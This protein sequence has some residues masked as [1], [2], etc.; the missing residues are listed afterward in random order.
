MDEMISMRTKLRSKAT[1]LGNDLRAYRQGD[2]KLMDQDQLALKIHHIEKIGSELRDVQIQLDKEGRSDDSDHI[3][4]VEDEVFLSSRLLARLEKAAEARGREKDDKRGPTLNMD[5]KSSL[6]IKFPTFYG[7]VMKW[8]EF[9][10]LYTASVHDNP[11]VVDVQKFV[12]LKSHLAGVALRAIQSIPVSADGY[13]EAIAVLKE[14]FELKD[15][16]RERLMKDLMN[17]QSVRSNDLQAMRSLIDHLTAHTRALNSLG[18]AT[19]SFSSLL[20]PIVKDKIPE[21]W[22]LE[23]ARRCS[24]DFSEFLKFLQQE[25]KVREA[26]RGGVASDAPPKP[27]QSVPPVSSSL[28]TQRVPRPWA[29]NESGSKAA[30]C[31]ACGKVGHRLF[32]CD[33]FKRMSGDARWRVAKESQ[34][35]FRC[36]AVGHRARDCQSVACNVCGRHH[37]SLLHP[38]SGASITPSGTATGLSAEAAPF[39]PSPASAQAANSGTGSRVGQQDHHRYNVN[40]Q[41]GGRCFFQTA[42]VEAEGPRGRRMTRAL[43]DGGSD[44]SYIRSSVVEELGLPVKDTGTFACIGFQEKAEEPRQYDRV[45]VDLRSRFGDGPIS[46]DLW[47]TERVCSPLPTPT[48]NLLPSAMPEMMAD[49]FGGGEVDILIGIDNLYHVVLWEQKDLGEG[50]RAVD[51]VFGYVIHGRHDSGSSEPSCRM[52]NHRC[53]V[54][55]LWDLETIGIKGK[56]ESETIPQEGCLP[57]WNEEEQRY[58]MGLV[59]RSTDRPVSNLDAAKIRTRRMAEKLSDERTHLYNEQVKDM[60]ENSVIEVAPAMTVNHPDESRG[61]RAKVHPN[62]LGQTD[63]PKGD[64]VDAICGIDPELDHGRTTADSA[65]VTCR[66]Q[67]T[68]CGVDPDLSRDPGYDGCTSDAFFLPHRGIFQKEKLRIVFDGSAKDGVGKG[69]NEYLY[70]GEN[71]LQ[72]L[73]A[74]VLC[75]RDGAIGCQSDIKAAFHQVSVRPEDRKYLQFFWSDLQLRF[76]R[77]P[78]GLSCSPYMLLRTIETHMGRYEASD[79]ELCNKI[80]TGLYMD[81]ICTTYDTRQEAEQGMERMAEIFNQANMQLHKSRVTGDPVPDSKVLG[82]I[83]STEADRLAVTVPDLPCPTTKSELL[84]MISRIFDPLG[85]LVPWLIGGKVLFQRMWNEAPSSKWDDALPD[86]LQREVKHWWKNSPNHRVWFPRQLTDAGQSQH[87]EFHV[88]C[89]ASKQA[90]CCAVYLVTDRESRLVMAKS[91]LAPLKP[92]LTI[93]RLELMAALIGARLMRFIE[94]ALRLQDPSVVF[95]T[96]STDVLHWLWNNKPRKV[97]VE[98]RVGSILEL[99]RPGQWR[100]VRGVENPADLGTRGVP[101]ST[102]SE[103]NKWWKG[104][105]HLSL[106]SSRQEDDDGSEF[107]LSSEAQKEDKI[108]SQRKQVTLT[109]A[110]PSSATTERD[111][112]FDVLR[113]SDLKSVVKRTAWIRRFVFNA[114]HRQSERKRGRLTSEERQ[115][116]LEHWIRDA[117][118][119]SFQSEMRCLKNDSLL[120][121]GSPLVKLRPQMNERGVLCAIPRTNEP[122]LPILPEFAHITTLIIDEAHRQCFHQNARVTL[123]LLSADYLVRRRSVNR[124]VSTCRRCRRY[125]GPAYQSADGCLPAFRTEPSRP[126]SKVGLDFFG[127]LYVD[128]GT[129]AWVLL[130]TCATSRAVHLELVRSQNTEDV[131]GALRKFFALRS[132]PELIISDN[133]K[134]FHAL[135][136]HIPRSVTWRFIPEA[137]PW[138]GGFWER[139][140]GITKKCLKITLHQCH[141]SFEELAVTLYELAFHLNI[142]PLTTS[143][144][145][146]LTPA[147]LLFGVNS[148]HGVIAHSGIH[149]DRVD[150]AWRHRRRIGD[151]L[152]RRWNREYIAALRSWSVSPRGRPSRVPAIGDIV[153]VHGEGPRSRWPL[154]RVEAL[155]TGPDG[156]ARAAHLVMRG[157][158]TRRPINK[159]FQLEA[160]SQDG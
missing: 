156:K 20:L 28:N 89:D 99:T 122:P 53:Q 26:A 108:E 44:S 148:I 154:A 97:F 3:Q 123:A 74:V 21:Q 25:I 129:K 31:N 117:Q 98:N 91:R 102:I 65:S 114:S 107:Q 132:T 146:L 7:D 52:T 58:E 33:K 109:A 43:L 50:L 124:V 69:L 6:T 137:A 54:E 87:G 100:H 39:S 1:K 131:K 94:D 38:P 96:D 139:M 93:P 63:E 141:L 115:Q 19:E 110:S 40:G 67:D 158:R 57:S 92:N 27:Q 127:P 70:S 159:L 12:I 121:V 45:S 85:V 22:R 84:S 118:E 119:N 149:D 2:S 151:N 126:F 112:L 106:E 135:L 16:C 46:L 160:S 37:H 76:A 111:R 90:Y 42:L 72:K 36:L 152:I 75:F 133:A 62:G 10:E 79:P 59:W 145:E 11:K 125:K 128:H 49:D 71:L 86:D 14:R 103:N 95:W 143:D 48:A 140:V 34:A 73:P 15:V 61:I 68:R 104:L 56:V 147:H 13:A 41:Y 157:K 8:S 18:V 35:C 153:L 32:Q 60:L 136:D 134:T 51:T 113:C 155:I 23:W 138:W 105:S 30:S 29:K 116:A 17:L 82:M 130:F 101:L 88:F 24:N 4:T 9:W 144:E 81:D 47:S 64:R 5:M 142:R 77:V 83:W 150:R 78:F 55:S 66:H 120:P 80:R